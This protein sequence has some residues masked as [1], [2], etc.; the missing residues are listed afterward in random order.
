[1]KYSSSSVDIYTD[2]QTKAH[3]C[4]S[5]LEEDEMDELGRG[6]EKRG[7]GVGEVSRRKKNYQVEKC[8][9]DYYNVGNSLVP[10]LFQ[11]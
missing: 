9:Y 11:M 1:M 10:G 4:V 6:K 5:H 3:W 2:L 7:K 8:C